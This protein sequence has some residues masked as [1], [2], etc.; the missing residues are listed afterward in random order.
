MIDSYFKKDFHK[1]RIKHESD[2]LVELKNYSYLYKHDLDLLRNIMT[3]IHNVVVTGGKLEYTY[4][5]IV[6]EILNGFNFDTMKYYNLK[7]L[8]TLYVTK[9]AIVNKVDGIE[10][11][12][13][14]KRDIYKEVTAIKFDVS[15]MQVSDKM[16]N[17]VKEMG[18]K[19]NYNVEASTITDWDEYF[20][21][22][23]V[24]VSRN[25]KCL[26][27]KVGAILVK[28]KS[29]ISTGYSGPPRGVPSCNNRWALD[30]SFRKKYKKTTSV[31][32][33]CPRKSIGFKSGEGLDICVAGHAE[34]NALINAARCGIKTKGSTLYMACAVPCTA[35]MVEIIN[36]G[37]KGIVVTS[38]QV[39]DES[40][41]Y[42]LENS[43]L[44]IR[45]YNFL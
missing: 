6:D 17:V 39:Y 26:S 13:K 8:I 33:E 12:I 19:D 28:D 38:M 23:C 44:K 14:L 18:N 9:Y 41:M 7:K 24:T 10:K 35:C 36:A 25:S 4:N 22:V 29:I 42:L 43:D 15:S 40:A 3:V 21:N 11:L 27:R 31:A 16:I 2:L 5:K 1:L 30:K 20:Y 32:S 37:V 34:R 45:L